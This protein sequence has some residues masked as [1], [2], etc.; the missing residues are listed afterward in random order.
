MVAGLCGFAIGTDTGGSIRGPAGMTGVFGLKTTE[1]TFPTDGVFAVSKTLDTI[2]PL[3]RSA[4]DAAI[5]FAAL[6]GQEAPRPAA[7]EGLR[8]GRPA[9]FFFDNLDEHVAGCLDAAL[10]AL[11]EA[12]A[13]VVE[14]DLPEID[15]NLSVFGNISRPEF[16]A[17]IGRDRFIREKDNINA[18][19]WD[20]AAAGLEV[21]A[22]DYIQSFWRYQELHGVAE[23]A[24]QGLDAWVGPSKQRVA[25]P[26]P[27]VT[28]VEE[29]RELVGLTAGPTRPANVFGMCASFTPVQAY[30]SDL[31]V[32]MQLMCLGGQDLKLMSIALAVEEVVGLPPTPDLT[33]FLDG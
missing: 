20:R 17:Y 22:D 2:G 11:A 18:D 19:V 8:I 32:G 7:I 24:M 31:P 28:S 25:P 10:A 23:R 4:A 3:T 13:E 12:G 5:V 29:A 15:E 16:V 33:G 14:F 26:Y 9:R 21:Q 1:R 27:G 6:V 30:G